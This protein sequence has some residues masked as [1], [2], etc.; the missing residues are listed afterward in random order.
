VNVF[1]T[2]NVLRINSNLMKRR[3]VFGQWKT[4]PQVLYPSASSAGLKKS[5]SMPTL[6]NPPPPPSDTTAK[7]EPPLED[8]TLNEFI[9]QE[10]EDSNGFFS[11]LQ[12]DFVN[13]DQI[14]KATS[15]Q[16]FHHQELIMGDRLDKVR[17]QL[18]TSS[19]D[20]AVGKRNAQGLEKRVPLFSN[21]RHEMLQ[22]D[23]TTE[24]I[25]DDDARN[26]RLIRNRAGARMRR[27]KKKNMVDLLKL[28]VEDLRH[29]INQLKTTQ[30]YRETHSN[31]SF[32]MVSYPNDALKSAYFSLHRGLDPSEE[33]DDESS[34]LADP[35]V[36]RQRIMDQLMSLT[37]EDLEKILLQTLVSTSTQDST[38]SVPRKSASVQLFLDSLVSWA[39]F[40]RQSSVQNNALYL[41]CTSDSKDGTSSSCAAEI[42]EHIMKEI[43][44]SESDV[45]RLANEKSSD[46]PT[47]PTLTKVVGV[48]PFPIKRSHKMDIDHLRKD[49]LS[50][51]KL[52][53][54]QKEHI[55]QLAR[56]LQKEQLCSNAFLRLGT[57]LASKNRM[58][59]PTV[60]QLEDAFRGVLFADQMQKFKVW[61][62]RNNNSIANLEVISP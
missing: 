19:D 5:T 29:A 4:P 44:L 46:S 39:E 50:K 3:A 11:G 55:S 25:G 32:G 9:F 49:L 7:L 35:E 34:I 62:N 43:L 54:D 47:I 28:E 56:G 2:N 53:N 60:G 48:D 24:S 21:P 18:L 23:D 45:G 22:T 33:D 38:I 6:P 14:K 20:A 17:H 42:R 40:V 31:E 13:P 10:P 58:D 57:S 59:F 37:K 61:I 36:E 41:L 30:R 12:D 16:D 15:Y 26:K 1:D 51:L 8:A 52:R 27:L